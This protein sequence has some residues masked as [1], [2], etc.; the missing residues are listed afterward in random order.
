MIMLPTSQI[1]IRSKWICMYVVCRRAWLTVTAQCLLLLWWSSSKLICRAHCLKNDYSRKD[2]ACPVLPCEVAHKM[3]SSV[4]DNFIFHYFENVNCL[5]TWV[6]FPALPSC[7][8]PG[9]LTSFLSCFKLLFRRTESCSTKAAYSWPLSVL[10][11]F[12]P[13]ITRGLLPPLH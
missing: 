6:Y 8:T 5:I 11:T 9:F 10:D 7:S 12:T 1:V 2:S 4:K 13:K 3:G